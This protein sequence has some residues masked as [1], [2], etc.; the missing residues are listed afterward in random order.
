[1]RGP[2]RPSGT[3][4]ASRVLPVRIPV[5]LGHA[6]DDRAKT[7]RLTAAT[8]ARSAIVAYLGAEPRLAVS[9]RR[10]RVTRP[11][12]SIDTVRLAEMRETTGKAV[13]T[14]RQVA[15]LDRER[16]GARLDEI[17]NALTRLIAA[18]HALDDWKEE[19]MRG[20]HVDEGAID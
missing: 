2:R 19:A 9:V 14:L 12:P 6:L 4:P 7:D 17:D 10:Y 5:A 16:G 11:A 13:G 18:A 15:G 8:I 3:P 1:M 20:S